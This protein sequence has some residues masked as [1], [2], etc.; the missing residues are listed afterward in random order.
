MLT[1]NTPNASIVISLASDVVNNQLPFVCE[2]DDKISG[3]PDVP[4]NNDGTTN[5]TNSIIVVPA[6]PQ[7]SRRKILFFSISNTDTGLA[8]VSI[9]YISKTGTP[10]GTGNTPRTIFQAILG[11]DYTLVYE[12]EY[13]FRLYDNN[14]ALVQNTTQSG[15]ISIGFAD[16]STTPI[17]TVTGSPVLGNGTIDISLN[18][19]SANLV[20]AGPTSG[21]PS[22]PAFRGLVLA[23][24]PA[25]IAAGLPFI[26]NLSSSDTSFPFAANT[27]YVF[28]SCFGVQAVASGGGQFKAYIPN[29]CTIKKVSLSAGYILIAPSSGTCSVYIR[30]NNSTDTLID[31]AVDLTKT[32]YSS[33][34]TVS[35]S[36]NAGD[37]IE[38]KIV[39]PA[40]WGATAI[41]G[42]FI[43]LYCYCD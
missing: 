17:Y 19:Q 37:Y 16:I 27:T 24:M 7:G 12:L 39:T 15:M 35:I 23:D 11:V 13:G 41:Q 18:T 6:P 5:N 14:G 43:T 10:P 8:Q 36:L 22:Q 21:G 32:N 1:L 25:G 30:K 40:S 4:G 42:M 2:W 9:Q 38:G 34:N 31:N 20:F 3:S 28:G 26:I 29:N 33:N